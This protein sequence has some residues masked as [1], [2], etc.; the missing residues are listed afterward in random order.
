MGNP[1]ILNKKEEIEKNDVHEN[2]KWIHQK[3]T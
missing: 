2:L 3:E 1:K